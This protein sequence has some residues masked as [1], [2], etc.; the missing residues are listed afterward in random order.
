MI[1]AKEGAGSEALC[2][3]GKLSGD[4]GVAVGRNAA[5]LASR[6]RQCDSNLLIHV[7]LMCKDFRGAS[8]AA[9]VWP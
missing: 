8:Y 4:D 9:T 1:G 5:T 2:T 3:V 6:S 7:V